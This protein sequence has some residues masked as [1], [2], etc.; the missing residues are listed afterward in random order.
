MG[1]RTNLLRT[2]GLQLIPVEQ[3]KRRRNYAGAV[4][5]R[6]TSDWMSTQASADAEIRTSIR[7][8]AGPLPRDGAEQS[9]CKA[10]KTHYSGQRGWQW[11]QASISSAAA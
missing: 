8:A 3:R 10:G 11:D 7:E 4:V 9:L 1:L 2:F 6:L 5:S